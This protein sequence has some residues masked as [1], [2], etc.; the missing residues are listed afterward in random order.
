M[1]RAIFAT[2]KNLGFGYKGRLPWPKIKEDMRLFRDVTGI[3]AIVM[4]KGTYDSLPCLL[5]HRVHVV[6]SDSA[7]IKEPVIQI[8]RDG[9]DKIKQ[10]GRYG[11]YSYRRDVTIIGGTS[12]LVP[13]FLK[14]CGEIYYTEV[15]GTFEADTF[16]SRDTMEYLENLESEEVLSTPK[17]ISRRYI[18]ER[19]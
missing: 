19:L 7:N 9:M 17:I 2:D 14:H 1:L 12:L 11:E 15:Q 8:P 18:N 3:G 16:I 10:F 6:V 5:P 13:E 4:G